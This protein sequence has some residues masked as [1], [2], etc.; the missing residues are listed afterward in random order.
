MDPSLLLDLLFLKLTIEHKGQ[1]ATSRFSFDQTAAVLKRARTSD[2]KQAVWVA[3][4]LGSENESLKLFAKMAIFDPFSL[5]DESTLMAK[6]PEKDHSDVKMWRQKLIPDIV[7]VNNNVV[8]VN[9][10]RI[11]SGYHRKLVRHS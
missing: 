2:E 1:K 10:K 9:T 4:S 5:E 6:F 11:R 7:V 8:A 3:A